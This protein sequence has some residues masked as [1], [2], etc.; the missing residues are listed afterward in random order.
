MGHE[1]HDKWK[2]INIYINTVYVYD[3]PAEMELSMME[4]AFWESSVWSVWTSFLNALCVIFCSKHA[5]QRFG[6]MFCPVL[7]S[8]SG[9]RAMTELLQDMWVSFSTTGKNPR[10]RNCKILIKTWKEYLCR[11]TAET[12]MFHFS[13]MVLIQKS[14]NMMWSLRG[15]LKGSVGS[16]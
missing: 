9:C 12:F 11:E 5:I 4:F 16:G 15:V 8:G 14:S 10:S 1:R 6:K 13:A 3:V 2:Y 7:W